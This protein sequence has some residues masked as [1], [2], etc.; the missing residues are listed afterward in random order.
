M[1]TMVK[2]LKEQYIPALILRGYRVVGEN[3]T[4]IVMSKDGGEKSFYVGRRGSL[5]IGTTM[6]LSCPCCETFKLILLE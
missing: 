2:T 5:R 3:S 6:A 4:H 1:T